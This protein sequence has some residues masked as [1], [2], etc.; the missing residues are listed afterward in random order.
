MDEPILFE[1][2]CT[3]CQAMASRSEIIPANRLPL[4]WAS[5]PRNRKQAFEQYRDASQPYLLYSGPGGSNGWVGDPISDERAEKLIA[6]F[7]NPSDERFAEADLYDG[8]GFCSSCQCYYCESCW[9]ASFSG[10]GRCPHGHFKSL[11]P[12]WSP[13]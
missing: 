6:A 3:R 8:A 5:W 11:D 7:E 4:E 1:P 13:E 2:R 10:G 12:H 9:N